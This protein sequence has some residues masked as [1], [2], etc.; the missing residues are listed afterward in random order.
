MALPMPQ[1]QATTAAIV[2]ARKEFVFNCP[3]IG[4]AQT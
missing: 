1:H 3:I 2:P 4:Q